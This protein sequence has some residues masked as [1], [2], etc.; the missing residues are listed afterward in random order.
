M[1]AWLR[2]SG[3]WFRQNMVIYCPFEYPSLGLPSVEEFR[4]LSSSPRRGE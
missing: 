1:M 4:S 3:A 2:Q